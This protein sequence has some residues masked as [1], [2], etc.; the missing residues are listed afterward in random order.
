MLNRKSLLI[1]LG[2]AVLA[3][4]TFFSQTHAQSSGRVTPLQFAGDTCVPKGQLGATWSYANGPV[5]VETP[6][7]PNAVSGQQQII[8]VAHK[9]ESVEKNIAANDEN[10]SS[11]DVQTLDSYTQQYNN[12]LAQYDICTSN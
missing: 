8:S 10:D 5:P 12:L 9:M 1:F 3:S 11:Q 2:V 4:F 7:D 6:A